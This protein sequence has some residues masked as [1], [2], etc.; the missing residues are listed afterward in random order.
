MGTGTFFCSPRVRR[1]S[2][3]KHPVSHSCRLSLPFVPTVGKAGGGG[4][5]MPST[6]TSWHRV[7]S[8]LCPAKGRRLTGADL[9]LTGAQRRGV[10]LGS[11]YCLTLSQPS[12][13]PH[14]TRVGKEK[15][16]T[17][18]HQ[19]R[20]GQS[21][22]TSFEFNLGK[23]VKPPG[24]GPGTGVTTPRQGWRTAALRLPRELSCSGSPQNR[25]VR[26]SLWRSELPT[27]P[28]GCPLAASVQPGRGGDAV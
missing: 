15:G 5:L 17:H 13:I 6:G 7:P 3:E 16:R 1:T 9:D 18:G 24:G 26:Y 21:R 23:D 25:G 12:V 19:T 11:P 8:G 28:P 27:R 22:S 10:V 14:L 2:P 4:V 20:A